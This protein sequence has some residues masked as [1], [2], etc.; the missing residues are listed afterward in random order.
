VTTPP[1]TT[2]RQNHPSAAMNALLSE[3]TTW[4]SPRPTSVSSARGATTAQISPAST[5]S[6]ALPARA[7]ANA[8]SRPFVGTL[9][10]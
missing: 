5:P 10:S 8:A 1:T 3:L 4:A 9:L 7:A 2:I 6:T